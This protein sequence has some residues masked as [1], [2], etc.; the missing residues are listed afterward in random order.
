MVERLPT[1]SVPL[2]ERD[3]KLASAVHMN[4]MMRD[5]VITAAGPRGWND[6]RE[7]WLSRAARK[8]GI[9][10]RRARS[11][12]YQQAG[13]YSPDEIVAAL[14]VLQ[15]VRSERTGEA[16]EIRNEMARLLGVVARNDGP[17]LGPLGLL[18]RHADEEAPAA[19]QMADEG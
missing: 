6:T 16:H 17:D 8:L 9:T 14:N 1:S 11:L 18:A 19:R 15:Q 10:H 12:F 7:S 13:K 2:H 5:A 3:K 4:E